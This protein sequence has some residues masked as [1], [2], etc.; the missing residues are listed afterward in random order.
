[1]LFLSLNAR[2]T[3]STGK[4]TRIFYGWEWNTPDSDYC[5]ALLSYWKPIVTLTVS[6]IKALK[7]EVNHGFLGLK[8]F[9]RKHDICLMW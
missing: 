4:N 6:I 2:I 3:Y 7:K 5:Y 9:R 8:R 1:M